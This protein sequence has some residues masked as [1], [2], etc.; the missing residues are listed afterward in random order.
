LKPTKQ[1]LEKGGL[2]W[3]SI[4]FITLIHFFLALHIC[5]C[6]ALNRCFY[7]EIDRK[8][9]S[10]FL[11]NYFSYLKIYYHIFTLFSYFAFDSWSMDVIIACI[12][13]WHMT[14]ICQYFPGRWLR[15]TV[16]LGVT[17]PYTAVYDEIRHEN[18]P[19]FAVILVTVNRYRIQ[20]RIL[21]RIR[22]YAYRILI[23]NGRKPPTW[24]PVK[25]RCVNGPYMTVYGRI[26]AVYVP[27]FS[28]R[29]LV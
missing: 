17:S 21:Y 2:G 19:H 13:I 3:L 18:G 5:R 15:I 28:T 7:S 22:S 10:L 4:Y 23:K 29:V 11:P 9:N 24:I 12:I 26:C 6:T 16:F 27:Y 25:I 1:E 8:K 14:T 20:H